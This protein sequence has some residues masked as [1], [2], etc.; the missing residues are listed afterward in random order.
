MYKV[1]HSKFKN[2]G[3]L[4]EI[5]IRRITADTLSGKESPSSLLLKKYFSNTE[6]GKEYKLYE[7][8]FKY[9]NITESK[10]NIIISTV[11]ESSKKLNRSKL[12][13]EKYNLIKELKEYYNL[14]EL[15]KIKIPEY[16]AYASLYTLFE[17]HNSPNSVNS[18]QIIDNKLT[19]IESLTN[20]SQNKNKVEDDILKEFK[21]YDKDLRIL[22]YRILLEKFNSKYSSLNKRQKYILKEFINSIDSTPNLKE[23]YNE[24]IKFIKNSLKENIKKTSNPT[25][26]IKLEEISKLLTELKKND[27]INNNNIVD[28]LQYH[29]LLEELTKIK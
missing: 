4:F 17:I 2:S 14:E 10:A 20:I 26:K 28:L 13:K 27:N 15:F 9:K 21:S 7:T 11:L 22:T 29:E 3:I 6:I 24:E 19:L 25:V 18:S 1:K 8:V 16:K 23:F 12:R 5:L